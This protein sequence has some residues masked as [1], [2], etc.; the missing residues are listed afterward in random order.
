VSDKREWVIRKRGY[1][2]R[3]NR[4]GYTSNINEAGRYTQAEATAEERVEPMLITAHLACEFEN[5][6]AYG[7]MD[8]AT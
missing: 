8:D 3:P 6:A 5:F 2:Y 1:F 4:A 7:P